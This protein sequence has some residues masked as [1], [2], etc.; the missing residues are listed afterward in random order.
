MACHGVFGSP[1]ALWKSGKTLRDCGI[2][3]V[4]VS[5]GALTDALLERCHQEGASVFV[6]FGVFQGKKVAEEHSELWPIGADGKRLEPDEWYLGLCPNQEDYRRQKLEELR[7]VAHEHA[8]DGLWLDFIRFPGH[9][10]VAR[11]R[12]EQSCFC[13][14]SLRQFAAAAHVTVPPGTTAERATWILTHKRAEW[15]RWKC[16]RIADFVHEARR[17][18]KAERPDALLGMFAVPWSPDEHDGAITAIVAQDMPLLARDIDVFSPMA[19]HRMCNRPVSWV[20]EHTR[21]L[22]G[23]TRKPVW[24]IV[25]A[26]DAPPGQT[27]SPGEFEEALRQGLSGEGVLVFTFTAVLENAEKLAALQRVYSASGRER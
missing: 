2:D 5:H 19:Y 26:T 7:R 6:E 14:A 15:T 24:P 21:F 22:T 16:R 8:I 10:E 23:A 3:A 13:D 25:Q 1:E 11:P 12:I 18:L 9:W 17:A 27:V 20:G 4:F